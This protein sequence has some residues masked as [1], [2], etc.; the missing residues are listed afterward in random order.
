MLD[1]G[2]LDSSWEEGLHGPDTSGSDWDEEEEEDMDEEDGGTTM[3]AG[4]PVPT[5]TK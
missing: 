2:A 4:T 5:A 1:V 3:E